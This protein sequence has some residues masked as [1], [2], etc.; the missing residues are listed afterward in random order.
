MKA[1]CWGWALL[2]GRC[3]TGAAEQPAV[4]PGWLGHSAALQAALD[5]ISRIGAVGCKLPQRPPREPALQ[6]SC[7]GTRP[8]RGALVRPAWL[9]IDAMKTLGRRKAAPRSRR[10]PE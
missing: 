1:A 10:P 5:S 3:S 4:P 7:T 2:A 9:G 6:Q 8:P